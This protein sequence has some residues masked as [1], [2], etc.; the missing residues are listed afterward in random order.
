MS[1]S[2]VSI[3][4]M[5]HR[6]ACVCLSMILMLACIG[7]LAEDTIV[8]NVTIIEPASNPLTGDIAALIQQDGAAYVT[9]KEDSTLHQDLDENFS[10]IGPVTKGTMLA[11]TDIVQ[12][13][14]ETWLKV[15]F[16]VNHPNEVFCGYLNISDIDDAVAAYDAV[17]DLDGAIICKSDRTAD[18]LF[19]M[20]H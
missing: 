5:L 14:G 2:K 20:K 4:K 6:P 9:V 13:M 1:K 15:W 10:F 17:K 19:E 3:F 16:V 12:Y 7:G 8:E 11:V 18:V